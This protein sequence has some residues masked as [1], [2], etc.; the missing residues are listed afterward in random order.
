MTVTK[1]HIRVGGYHYLSDD[2]EDPPENGP[3]QNVCKIMTNVIASAAEAKIGESFIN[4][5]VA[6]PESTTLIEIGHP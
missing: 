2:S 1:A 6:V 3:I 4:L 5:Q